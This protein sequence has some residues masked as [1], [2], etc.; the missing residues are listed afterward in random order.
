MILIRL[1]LRFLLVPLGGFFA[2]IAATFVVCFAHWT[3]FL[4]LVANDPTA[5]ENIVLAVIFIGPALLVIMSLG[6]FA[7]LMP[8]AIGVAISEVF[9]I[10]SILFHAANGALASWIGWIVMW[11][12]LKDFEFFKEPTISIGAGIAAGLTYW[13]IAG[14]NAGFWKPVFSQPPKP[15]TAA[16]K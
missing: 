10:R 6:A 16:S 12:F 13:A 14:W 7:M 11:E 5:P 2:A 9:A 3:Q 8:A 4:K 1:L 15:Q